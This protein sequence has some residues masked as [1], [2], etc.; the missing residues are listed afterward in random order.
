MISFDI[1]CMPLELQVQ[2]KSLRTCIELL[3][4]LPLAAED[5]SSSVKTT[6]FGLDG[7]LL[8]KNYP[9]QILIVRYVNQYLVL[10]ELSYKINIL[11]HLALGSDFR[12]WHRMGIHFLHI[13]DLP[14]LILS[15]YCLVQS[16]QP[17]NESDAENLLPLENTMLKNRQ[18]LQ[19]FRSQNRD[20]ITMLYF[21]I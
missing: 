7:W 2:P 4:I 8:A 6:I 12:I 21:Y 1:R 3:S 5:L 19:T 10:M 11:E 20:Y 17:K 16:N 18:I 15:Y 9:R 13:Y 14:C